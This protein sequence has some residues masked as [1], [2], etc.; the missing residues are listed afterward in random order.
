MSIDLLS[1][2]LGEAVDLLLLLPFQILNGTF[3]SLGLYTSTPPATS[4]V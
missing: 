4:L 2:I 1:L 3:D